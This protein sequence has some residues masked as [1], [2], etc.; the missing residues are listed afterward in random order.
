VVPAGFHDGRTLRPFAQEKIVEDLSHARFDGPDAH[1]FQ[2]TTRPNAVK[3]DAYSFAKAPRYDGEVAQTGPLGEEL[4]LGT[5]LFAD[6]YARHG[7]SVYV[8]ELA[9]LLRPAR[10]FGLLIRETEGVIAHLDEPL[11]EKPKRKAHARG[12]GLTHAARGALGHWLTIR[13]GK[14]AAYQIVSPTTWN[15]SPRDAQNR[16]GPWEQALIGTPVAD[17]DHPVEMGHVLRSFDPCLV[18]TVHTLDG[19]RWRLGV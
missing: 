12:A 13:Q 6:L 8:R 2:G 9:R 17:P 16:P 18:C 1:P 3:A 5:P 15:G 10:Y 19:Q 4:A 14:I 7:D 11:Y